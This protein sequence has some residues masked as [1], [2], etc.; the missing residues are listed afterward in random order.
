M[1]RKNTFSLGSAIQNYFKVL[2]FEDKLLEAKIA[3]NWKEIVGNVIA[4]STKEVF[5]NKNLLY[6]K[7]DSAVIKNEMKFLKDKLIFKVNDFVKK[8]FIKDLIIF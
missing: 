2:G 1:K 8:D 4:T 3:N 7:I 6:I 5:V